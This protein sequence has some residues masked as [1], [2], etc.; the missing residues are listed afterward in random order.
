MNSEQL[1]VGVEVWIVRR[2]PHIVPFVQGPF[3]VVSSGQNIAY[4]AR[5]SS[6]GDAVAGEFFYPSDLYES[7]EAAEESFEKASAG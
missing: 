1:A 7:R 3:L 6:A 2:W 5:H 4:V